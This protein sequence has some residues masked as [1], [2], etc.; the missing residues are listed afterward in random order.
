[1]A[2]AKISALTAYTTPIATDVLPIVDITNATTKKIAMSDVANY[3]KLQSKVI[4]ATRDMT[5]ASG[6]VAYTGVGFTPSAI[7]VVGSING[8]FTFTTGFVDS[9]KQG[10][11]ID[12]YGNNQADNGTEF[13]KAYTSAST[14]QSAI[15]KSFDSDGFTLTWT[16]TST[17][18]GTLKLSFIC[19]R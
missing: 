16:K 5:A 1:M 12:Y 14:V 7:F 2:D 9:S 11:N 13:L 4:T 3:V 15:V 8:T 18:T 6:D 17:P 10:A 19:F